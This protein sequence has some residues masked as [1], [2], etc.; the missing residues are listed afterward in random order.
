MR[1]YGVGRA[2]T[3]ASLAL[4][5]A[6]AAA[7][8]EAKPQPVAAAPFPYVAAKAYH[9]LPGTHTDESGYFSLCEGR[10]GAVYVGTA[11]YGRN[12]YLVEFDPVRE[13]QRIVIDTHALCGLTATGY[14]AQAKIHTRN[15]VGPSGMIYVGSKQGYRR[16]KEDTADYPGGYV[17]TY[18]PRR[19]LAESLGMP[20]ATEGVIDVVAD[21]PRGLLYVVTCE[22]QHWLRYERATA[23]YT[24]LG[25]LLTPYA[26][27]LVG[28]D[29]RA[30]VVTKDWQ[31]AQYDPASGKIITR[32][33]RLGAGKWVEKERGVLT[34]QLAADGHTAYAIL[35]SDAHLYRLDL[36]AAGAT[37]AVEDLGALVDGP[38]PDSRAALTIARDG[39]VYVLVRVDNTTGFGKG[40][41]HWLTR[42]DPAT[43]KVERLGVLKVSNPDF[44]A[45][46]P[47]ADGKPKPWTHGYHTLPDGA[48]TPLHAH[49]GLIAGADG[50]LYATILYPYTLLRIE[51][52]RAPAPAPSVAAQYVAWALGQVD[53]AERELPRLTRVAEKLAARHLAGGLIGFP[54]ELAPLHQELIGRSGF[55]VNIG[56]NRGYKT[57]R[58]DAEKANDVAITGWDRPPE[59]RELAAL[60]ALKARGVYLVGFG[61]KAM[62]ELREHIA[63]CDEWFDTGLPADGMALALPGGARVGRGHTLASC[64][65]AWGL[66]AELVAALTRAGKMPAMWKSY[67]Y[68]DGR[69]WGAKYLGKLQWHDGPPV[70]PVAAGELARRYYARLRYHLRAL[71]RGETGD[72]ERVAALIADEQRAG[73]KTVVATSGHMPWRYVGFFADQAWAEPYDLHW[74]VAGQMDAYRKKA[75]ADRLVLRLDQVGMHESL[76]ALFKEKQQHVIVVHGDHPDAAFRVPADVLVDVDGG[77]AFGDACVSLPG[78]PIPILPP[79]GIMQLVIYQA[80][81]AQ[82]EAGK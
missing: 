61:P 5:L 15:F 6:A 45:F 50:T 72:L 27:T 7:G 42:F 39:R 35:M 3:T 80:I 62:P 22:Q 16:G 71:A 46:G 66:G 58:T 36:T 82:V 37:V 48:L 1:A 19:D 2:M 76:V 74:T 41:L 4:L 38:H 54:H 43:A 9:V 44:F 40:F 55:M 73:R 47:G 12:A 31:L 26:T 53:A 49:M 52:F 34:W 78:F 17:M 30:S 65:Q 79:S 56:F 67:A 69:E 68:P 60:Q 32:D 11:A 25:P 23:K 29:G 20:F 64:L 33:L 10:D 75:P 8:Q 59:A 57:E 81:A 51:A 21:E 28:R 63:L 14:A 13:T 70:P 18:D 77:W 24:E